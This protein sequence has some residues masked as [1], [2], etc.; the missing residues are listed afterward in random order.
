MVSVENLFR[1][2]KEFKKNKNKKPDVIAFSLNLENNIF[3]LRD[4]LIAKNWT[5]DGYKKFSINDPKPRIIHKATVRD[6]VLYQAVYRILYPLFDN[7]FIFDSYSSRNGKGTHAGIKRLNM[8]LRKLS[9]N[10]IKPVYVLK[11][12]IRKFFDSIDH[13]ILLSLLRQK[14]DCIETMKVLE[15]IINSFHKSPGK[16]LP[17]GNVTSQLFANVYFNSFDWYVKKELEIKYYVRYCDDFV[18]PSSNPSNL[19]RLVPLLQEFLMTKLK[20]ELH[21]NKVSIRKFHQGIDFLGAVLLPRHSVLRTRT[22]ERIIDKS[23]KLLKQFQAGKLSK[24]RAYQSLVSYLGH[25]S[26]IKSRALTNMLVK[27]QI[28]LFDR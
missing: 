17:L 16:G 18:I 24:E 5:C 25:L 7:T 27:M 9:G 23:Y 2:W 28:Q 6:R 3:N 8:F 10:Y 26:H 13:E 19:S 20:L 22:K 4:E 1:A 12:D 14:I 15:K 11:C 21:P